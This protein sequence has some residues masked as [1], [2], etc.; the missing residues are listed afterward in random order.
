[1]EVHN[2]Y[3]LCPLRY[4]YANADAYLSNP[5]LTTSGHN[6]YGA[7]HC[8]RAGRNITKVNPD[9]TYFY[10]QKMYLQEE[11]IKKMKK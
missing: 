2:G 3:Q 4:K 11:S 5:C 10:Y 7:L 8:C 6:M 1:M 9:I